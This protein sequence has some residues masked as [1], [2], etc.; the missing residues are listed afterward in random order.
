MSDVATTAYGDYLIQTRAV[1]AGETWMAEYRIS[2][3]GEVKIPWKRA[4]GI[5]GFPTHGSA[6]HAA[7]A[8]AQ[9]DIDHQRFAS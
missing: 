6:S 1:P 8:C 9:S 7:L 3:N 4:A 5:G 2:Q